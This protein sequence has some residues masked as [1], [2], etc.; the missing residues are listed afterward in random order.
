MRRWT[1]LPEIRRFRILP[2]V[3][4]VE[5]QA[6]PSPEASAM[7]SFE[8]NI[9]QGNELRNDTGINIVLRSSK[10][11][12]FEE[13]GTTIAKVV[14]TLIRSECT[15]SLTTRRVTEEHAPVCSPGG[16]HAALATVATRVGSVRRKVQPWLGPGERASSVPPWLWTMR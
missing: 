15:P 10:E 11:R 12:S 9:H 2:Q 1:T 13:R 14:S 5:P 4:T 8:C 3:I 16:S 7:A 6:F